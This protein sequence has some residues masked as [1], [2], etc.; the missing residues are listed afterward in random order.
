MEQS[1]TYCIESVKLISKSSIDSNRK[2]SKSW[3][4]LT[5]AYFLNYSHISVLL[6]LNVLIN[7]VHIKGMQCKGDLWVIHP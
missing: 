3:W 6:S 1:N 2:N 7:I 5:L 4:S